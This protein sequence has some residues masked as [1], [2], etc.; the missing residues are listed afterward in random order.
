ME[1]KSLEK[2]IELLIPNLEE[3]NK[4]QKT[5]DAPS[6]LGTKRLVN[7]KSQLD[8]LVEKASILTKLGMQYKQL[9]EKR[10]P[11]LKMAEVEVDLLGNEVEELLSLL[12]KIYITLDHYTPVLQHYPRV[13]LIFTYH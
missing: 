3:A 5:F 9:L 2:H 6:E 1:I 13:R 11:D 7:S 4:L 8:S 10:C 12:A